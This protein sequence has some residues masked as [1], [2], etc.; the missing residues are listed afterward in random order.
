MS[1]LSKNERQ[2][3]SMWLKSHLAGLDQLI[4]RQRRFRLNHKNGS[5]VYCLFKVYLVSVR[6]E[7]PYEKLLHLM[8]I[9]ETDRVLLERC[10]VKDEKLKSL[11]TIAAEVA[12]EIKNTVIAI[13]GFAKRLRKTMPSSKEAR[14]IESESSRLERLVKSINMYIR[15]GQAEGVQQPVEQI[16]TQSLLLMAPE[17]KGRNIRVDLELQ[18]GLADVASD[19]DALTEVFVN[20][21]RN[22]VA[23]LKTHGIL[24]IRSFST[25]DHLCIEFENRMEEKSVDNVETLFKPIEDGGTSIGLPLSFRIVK[26]LGGN[27]SFEKRGDSAVFKVEIPKKQA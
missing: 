1:I 2:K 25:G 26:N 8:I 22:A 21:I 14:L 18:D 17:L 20:L 6:P 16:L 23:A 5:T 10:A 24:I 15:P 4:P 11:G 9:D 12:H 27:L 13:G 3:C 7:K 19:R